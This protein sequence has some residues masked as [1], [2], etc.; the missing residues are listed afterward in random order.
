MGNSFLN[1]V[2]NDL[3][4][5]EKQ[6]NY[7][8]VLPSKR[9]VTFFKKELAKQNNQARFL[10]KVISIDS[11][12]EEISGLILATPSELEYHLYAIYKKSEYFK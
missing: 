5:K 10:P 9:A 6:T 1:V 12:I 7:T 8:V 3:L 2:I 11:F 4:L